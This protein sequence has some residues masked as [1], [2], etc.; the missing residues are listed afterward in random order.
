LRELQRLYDELVD[1]VDTCRLDRYNTSDKSSR[2][3][4]CSLSLDTFPSLFRIENLSL[5]QL[6]FCVIQKSLVLV[7]AHATDFLLTRQRIIPLWR[8]RYRK[9]HV[10]GLILWSTV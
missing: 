4:F 3:L 8:C 10:D 9:N 6:C 7:S 2:W 1:S 5:T